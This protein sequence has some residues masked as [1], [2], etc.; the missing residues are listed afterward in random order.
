MDD[1]VNKEILGR[2]AGSNIARR[3]ASAREIAQ[4]HEP[5]LKSP[6]QLSACKIIHPGMRDRRVLDAFRGLRTK[7]F[8]MN[9]GDGFVVMIT[10]V[11]PRPGWMQ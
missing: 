4:M 9:D 3:L 6:E 1:K 7:L 5:S 2:D 8:G 10:P 11:V